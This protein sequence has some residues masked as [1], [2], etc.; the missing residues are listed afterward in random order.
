MCM[1][2]IGHHA[3]F[4][5]EKITADKIFLGQM[6]KWPSILYNTVL[7]INIVFNR[8]E[9]LNQFFS[10]GWENTKIYL[11]L[12]YNL[13]LEL[14][15][16]MPSVF[17]SLFLFNSNPMLQTYF[18]SQLQLEGCYQCLTPSSLALSQTLTKSH[19]ESACQEY[20]DKDSRK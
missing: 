13:V 9:S 7:N 10:R 17:F 8:C 20:S 6:I 19:S 11:H 2:N 16:K 5:Y 14:S 15:Q 12:W 1:L 3:I 4:S 18:L